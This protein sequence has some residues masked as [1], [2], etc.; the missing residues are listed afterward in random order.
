MTQFQRQEALFQQWKQVAAQREACD[1]HSDEFSELL[2]KEMALLDEYN[3][4]P[5]DKDRLAQIETRLKVLMRKNDADTLSLDEGREFSAL[6]QEKIELMNELTYGGT[7]PLSNS[8]SFNEK[9]GKIV[10]GIFC[11]IVLGSLILG[12]LM[13][14]YVNSL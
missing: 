13:V 14:L 4:V 1:I 11:G 6:I 7:I 9:A 10:T 3:H 8:S 2:K 12:G 5:S